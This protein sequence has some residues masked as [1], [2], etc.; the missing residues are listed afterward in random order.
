MTTEN[1]TYIQLLFDAAEAKVESL[2]KFGWTKQDFAD[3]LKQ[4][5][6]REEDDE[7]QHQTS[8]GCV[9]PPDKS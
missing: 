3:A 1:R 2:K 9:F 4:V 7:Q 5:L 8:S 6:L